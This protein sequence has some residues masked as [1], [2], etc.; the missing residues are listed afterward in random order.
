MH[1]LTWGW[2]VTDCSV[3][4]GG[5]KTARVLISLWYLSVRENVCLERGKQCFMPWLRTSNCRIEGLQVSSYYTWYVFLQWAHILFTIR[6]KTKLLWVCIQIIGTKSKG[7]KHWL[8]IDTAFW[9]T[10]TVPWP[11]ISSPLWNLPLS[12][13]SFSHCSLSPKTDFASLL[14]PCFRE[15]AR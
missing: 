10:D 7:V 11:S 5:D 15:I 8:W 3:K 13:S 6:E 9:G 12:L 2:P 14:K 4:E 1:L